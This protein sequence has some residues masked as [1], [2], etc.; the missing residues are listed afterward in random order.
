MEKSEARFDNLINSLKP[1]E[2]PARPID[3]DK[4]P[5]RASRE[6]W[7]RA[8]TRAEARDKAEYWEAV[9]KQREETDRAKPAM[10]AAT[11]EAIEKIEEE[12]GIN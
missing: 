6:S 4:K 8:R 5:A 3:H 1:K 12:V 9:K 11:V 2:A 7:T 10:N